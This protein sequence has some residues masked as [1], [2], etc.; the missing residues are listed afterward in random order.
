MRRLIENRFGLLALVLVA[1]GALYGV[2]HVSRPAPVAQA[3]P[4]AV[5]APVE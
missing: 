5:M 3:R 1:L 2:A 4:Q